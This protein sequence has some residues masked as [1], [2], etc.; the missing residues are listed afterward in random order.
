MPKLQDLITIG[1]KVYDFFDKLP[2]PV[3]KGALAFILVGAV[4]GPILLMVGKFI[5]IGGEMAQTVGKIGTMF[6]KITPGHA[7]RALQQQ[8]QAAVKQKEEAQK[9]K[10]AIA[11]IEQEQADQ[12]TQIQTDGDKTALDQQ[13]EADQASIDQ[14][15]ATADKKAEIAK[16]G[17]V[18][19]EEAQTTTGQGL[20]A[21]QEEQNAE[22]QTAA[23]AG[24]NEKV[25]AT[26]TGQAQQ[27]A[28]TKTGQAQQTAATKTGQTEQKAAVTEGE[29]QQTSATKTGQTQQKTAVTEG[30]AQQTAATKTGQTRQK[31]AVQT[32]QENQ[33]AAQVAGETKQ[34]TAV[35]TGLGAQEVE[36]VSGEAVMTADTV[37]G[38]TDQLEAVVAGE[39]EQDEAVEAGMATQEGEVTAGESAMTAERV[40]GGAEG[41]AAGAGGAVEGGALAAGEGAAGLG[42]GAVVPGAMALM[43]GYQ[44]GGII[45]KKFDLSGKI[46]NLFGDIFGGAGKAVAKA[47]VGIDELTDRA[48]QDLGGANMKGAKNLPDLLTTIGAL[49]KEVPK[50]SGTQQKELVQTIKDLQGDFV[51][52]VKESKKVGYTGL[53]VSGTAKAKPPKS[54]KDKAHGTP[55]DPDGSKTLDAATKPKKFPAGEMPPGSTAAVTSPAVLAATKALAAATSAAAAYPDSA[56]AKEALVTAKY[57]YAMAKAQQTVTADLAKGTATGNANATLE[58]AKEAALTAAYR[59]AMAKSTA[60]ATPSKTAVN[61]GIGATVGETTS[62]NSTLSKDIA[63]AV[64]QA[65]T[66][67][68]KTEAQQRLAVW[69]TTLSHWQISYNKDMA[70]GNLAAA[71]KVLN[72]EVNGATKRLAGIINTAR[73]EELVDIKE[74]HGP[75]AAALQSFITSQQ[76]TLAKLSQQT[77]IHTAAIQE[78]LRVMTQNELGIVGTTADQT[79]KALMAASQMTDFVSKIGDY[80]NRAGFNVEGLMAKMFGSSSGTSQSIMAGLSGSDLSTT[81]ISAP[82]DPTAL[83]AAN[84]R[85]TSLTVNVHPNAIHVHGAAG[86]NAGD[87]VVRGLTKFAADLERQVRVQA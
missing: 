7:D 73:K 29:A 81:G 20:L 62:L 13:K 3:K 32:G 27:T 18:E 9:L 57:N 77:G 21:E 86:E 54:L 37:T 55:V 34:T 83:I 48:G 31:T 25:A 79:N 70:A 12:K 17:G 5:K 82:V 2:G 11:K 38:Q 42:A 52:Y 30:E 50:V 59:K 45:N 61:R 4:L 15:Q 74:G 43:A 51:K 41:A 67:Q 24:A 6:G 85:Q 1:T 8:A 10:D 84:N 14:A 36:V 65:V 39:T 40:A 69:K 66:A 49:E 60:T 64:G 16:Q 58:R 33:R 19:Q 72:T 47:S 76:S 53:G 44:I 26:K 68:G 28:A 22:Q 35:E 63:A 75:A 23:E 46:T 56:V 87:S 78:A 80:A 71:Q